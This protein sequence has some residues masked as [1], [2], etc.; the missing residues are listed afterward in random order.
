MHVNI[1]VLSSVGNFPRVTVAA[2]GAHGA[3]VF[4]MQGI[5]V[6]TPSAAAVA[7]AT[8]GFAMEKHMPKGM[9]FTSGT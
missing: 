8:A 1:E 9:I 3:G 6:S 2:P 4:G 7:E 5:G